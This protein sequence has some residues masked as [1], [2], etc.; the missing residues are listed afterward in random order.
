M[1]AQSLKVCCLF[2]RLES[3]SLYDILQFY[4]LSQ[5]QAFAQ[6]FEEE[7]VCS[8]VECERAFLKLIERITIDVN[9]CEAG[10]RV[11][12]GHQA[13]PRPTR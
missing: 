2:P 6:S 7:D 13:A 10:R 9:A 1:T 5:K 3:S 12:A 4:N 11:S 8:F